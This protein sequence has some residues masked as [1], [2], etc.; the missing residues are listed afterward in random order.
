LHR[1]P[2]PQIW[3]AWGVILTESPVPPKLG[4]CLNKM[5][6]TSKEQKDSEMMP[7]IAL[8]GNSA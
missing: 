6:T 2:V 4:K 3:E 7:V 8:W 5:N 1:L